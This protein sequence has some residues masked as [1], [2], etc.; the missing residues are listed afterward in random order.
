MSLFRLWICNLWS[1]VFVCWLCSVIWCQVVLFLVR[2]SKHV[3]VALL[4][5]LLISMKII[6]QRKKGSLMLQRPCGVVSLILLVFVI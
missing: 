3:S 5:Y 4:Y 2:G 6:I 1:S